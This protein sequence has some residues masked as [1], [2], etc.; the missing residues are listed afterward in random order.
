MTVLLDGLA[1]SSQADLMA[2]MSGRALY[3]LRYG[4]RGGAQLQGSVEIGGR[5]GTQAL[6]VTHE[7]PE[8]QEYRAGVG[9][10]LLLAEHVR[11]C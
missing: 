9:R 5:A 11:V 4:R 3:R 1:S 8:G 6:E 10:P 2:A 7:A